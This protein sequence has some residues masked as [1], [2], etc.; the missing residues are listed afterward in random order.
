VR[1]GSSRRTEG[2]DWRVTLP[3]ALGA[4]L[5]VIKDLKS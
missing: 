3:R 5:I 4:G 2:R 1:R